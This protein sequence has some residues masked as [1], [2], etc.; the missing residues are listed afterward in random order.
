MFRTEF[1]VIPA[2]GTVDD[3]PEIP[4]FAEDDQPATTPARPRAGHSKTLRPDVPDRSPFG[5]RAAGVEGRCHSEI[6]FLKRDP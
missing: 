6:N 1:G 4:R 2:E 5:R 3:M